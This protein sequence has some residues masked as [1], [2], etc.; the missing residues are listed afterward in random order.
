MEQTDLLNMEQTDLLLQGV[1][2]VADMLIKELNHY[3]QK[4]KQ[5]K[6]R[7][8]W[9][10]EWILRRK[11]QGASD[12]F[13]QEV[14]MEDK[15][16]YKNH[17]RLNG[18][19]F[20]YLLQKVTPKIQ[21]DDTVMRAALPAKIKLQIALRYLATGDSFATLQSSFR[22]PKSTISKFLPEVLDAIY[23]GLEKYI[24]VSNKK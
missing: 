22:I 10:R 1:A 8:I 7:S 21:R 4:K 18:E 11:Q 13:L 9:A 14:R 23:E 17:L 15:A 6:K 3:K 24:Q 12:N 19:Q 2:V 16:T 20:D 5:R